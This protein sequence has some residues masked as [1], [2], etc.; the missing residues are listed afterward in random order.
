MK[1][2]YG[3]VDPWWDN[4]YKKLDYQYYSTKF[5]AEDFSLWETQGYD[6]FHINGGLYDMRNVM[7][8]FTNGF[9]DLH[10]WND[11]GI[12]YYCMKPFDF[13]PMHQDHY[14]TYIK[15]FKIDNPL[16]IW[17]SVIFLENWK[18]GHYLEIDGLAIMN[19]KAGDWVAWNYNVPH[20]AGNV[21]IEN[22]Y[23]VQITGWTNEFV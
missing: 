6:R 4:T 17:R 5:S 23:T 11:V 8:A 21:G 13:L 22:R 18:S 16:K 12:S 10:N 1:M 15:K 7:P 2:Q 20:A 14:I 19:W 3:H 9:F